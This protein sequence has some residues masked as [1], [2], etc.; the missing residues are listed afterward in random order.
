MICVEED[1]HR[2]ERLAKGVAAHNWKNLRK[3]YVPGEHDVICGRGRSCFYHIGNQRFRTMVASCL[4]EYYSASTKLEKTFIICGI[5]NEV[6]Q[7]SQNGG[8][9]KCDPMT[10]Q[11]FEVGDFLAVR[12]LKICC[13]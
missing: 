1:P 3:N 5:V 13:S 8:F 6:R 9:V 4:E 10:G 2:P 7:N 11:F 12:N